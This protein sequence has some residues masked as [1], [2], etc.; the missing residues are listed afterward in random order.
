VDKTKKWGIT[1]VVAVLL[2]GVAAFG[3]TQIVTAQNDRQEVVDCAIHGD[4]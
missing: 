3:A 4:C 2:A 1:A